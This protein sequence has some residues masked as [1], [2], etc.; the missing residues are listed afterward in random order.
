MEGY[1]LED[2]MH[3]QKKRLAT[4]YDNVQKEQDQ[5]W[6]ARGAAARV[7]EETEAKEETNEETKSTEEEDNEIYDRWYANLSQ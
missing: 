4:Y 6:H 5:Q 2:C 3:E 1:S 7:E